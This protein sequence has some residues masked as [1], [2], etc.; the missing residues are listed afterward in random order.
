MGVFGQYYKDNKGRK[1][2]SWFSFIV[3]PY[4]HCG[5]TCCNPSGT[6]GIAKVPVLKRS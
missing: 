5:L 3:T 6:G 2:V 4:K 1:V